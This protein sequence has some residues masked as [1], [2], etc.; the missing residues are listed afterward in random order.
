ML[1]ANF[2]HLE[3]DDAVEKIPLLDSFSP[4][5]DLQ[6]RLGRT[7]RPDEVVS[8]DDT[9]I[10]L[11]LRM[12][13][14]GDYLAIAEDASGMALGQMQFSVAR[15]MGDTLRFRTLNGTSLEAGDEIRHD[16]A[17]VDNGL[18]GAVRHPELFLK[19]TW[20]TDSPG[21][22]EVAHNEG[23]Y[24]RIRLKESGVNLSDS[25]EWLD[26]YLDVEQ[27][28]PHCVATDSNGDIFTDE[29]G[30]DWIFN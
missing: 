24:G 10:T 8:M 28:P 22:K 13:S 17:M 14:G 9:Q 4:W 7:A 15:V 6:M 30:D 2:R 5:R 12:T 20:M 27:K 18:E 29:N 25:D 19:M 21:R 3:P 23:R 26:T 11:D 16:M 1:F